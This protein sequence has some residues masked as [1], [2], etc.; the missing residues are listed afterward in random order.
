[1]IAKM[2]IKK[3]KNTYYRQRIVSKVIKIL[4]KYANF[5]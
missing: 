1:M 3:N 5:T 2:K 4:R